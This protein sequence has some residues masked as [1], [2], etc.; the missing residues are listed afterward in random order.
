M[1]RWYPISLIN[2]LAAKAKREV[3]HIQYTHYSI[4]T[5]IIKYNTF[6]QY[7]TPHTRINYYSLRCLLAKV[8]VPSPDLVK[9]YLGEE[10]GRMM[11]LMIRILIGSTGY[12]W[13]CE[14]LNHQAL[15]FASTWCVGEL[16][17]RWTN[18]HPQLHS[19][20][21]SFLDFLMPQYSPQDALIYGCSSNNVSAKYY[22]CLSDMEA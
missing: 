19:L 9:L 8:L 14:K 3:F 11:P 22:H 17:H 12:S 6:R 4:K 20:K 13:G 16:E 18:P 5:C 10:G 15:P 7:L 2:F 1:T 21:N